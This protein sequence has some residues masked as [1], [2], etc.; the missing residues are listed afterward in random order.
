MN[1]MRAVL[2]YDV[3]LH[4]KLTLFLRIKCAALIYHQQPVSR[5]IIVPAHY[6]V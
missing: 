2:F 1:P 3:N 5:S 6:T 4:L